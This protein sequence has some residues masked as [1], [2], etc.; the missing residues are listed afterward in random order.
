[1]REAI[2]EDKRKT[3]KKAKRAERRKDF[4]KKKP[5]ATGHA[6]AQTGTSAAAKAIEINI[7]MPSLPK[8]KIPKISWAQV[9]KQAKRLP[10]KAWI[11]IAIFLFLSVGVY[12]IPLFTGGFHWP[13][14]AHKA[15]AKP[16]VTVIGKAAPAGPVK[17]NPT[18][19]TITPDGKTMSN[20]SKISPPG[21][22]P[23]YAYADKIGSV[24]VD[25][26]E[27]PL[28]TSFKADIA[29]QVSS[30]AQG[31]NA[32][33]KMIIGATTVYIG[34]ASG[35]AQSLI[36]TQNSLLI[37]MRSTGLVSTNQW[38]DYIGRLQ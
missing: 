1:L 22:D 35:G 32:T 34:T 5:T 24:R 19:A 3:A 8:L 13:H 11:G 7:S 31:F 14:A 18:Y 36:F 23:V 33:Q 6:K 30:L 4:F 38:A 20:W 16:K 12:A 27:Q 10:R 9:K 15:A 28:P 26:S 21:R 2:E 37:L 25:V 29:G 17:G